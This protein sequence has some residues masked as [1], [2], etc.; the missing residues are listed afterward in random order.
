[1]MM[2]II[3]CSLRHATISDH[4]SRRYKYH[5]RHSLC[6]DYQLWAGTPQS[7]S[8]SDVV[9]VYERIY[10]SSVSGGHTSTTRM[11]YF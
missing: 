9:V 10:Y 6:C 3:K 11:G 5:D 1:M 4:L 2:M 8:E 7:C